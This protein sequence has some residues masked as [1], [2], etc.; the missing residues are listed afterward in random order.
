L[1][2]VTQ[3]IHDSTRPRYNKP[4]TVRGSFLFLSDIEIPFHN[5]QFINN[6]FAVAKAYNIRQCVIG[7]DWFHF[8]AFS[9]WPGADQDAEQEIDEIDEHLPEFLQP[10]DKLYYFLGN[11]DA[12]VVKVMER[13]LRADQ[14][15]RMVIAPKLAQ[16][17]ER[18]VE[19]TSNWWMLASHNWE[20]SH[21]PKN[22]NMPATTAKA[23]AEARRKNV[24]QAH[25]HKWGMLQDVSGR[26]VAI[27]SGCCVD[28]EKLRYANEMHSPSTAMVNGAV[29]MLDTG[30]LYKPLL[31]SPLVTDFDYEIRKAKR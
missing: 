22:R 17:F 20:L 13:K 12:R 18:K 25:T 16:E 23:L 19:T 6:V 2:S 4:L 14:A 26:L 1:P 9:P 31:L 30:T 28:I 27:E 7:G 10:F 15:L 21:A 5:A 3:L 11:H 8:E 29:L 24:I